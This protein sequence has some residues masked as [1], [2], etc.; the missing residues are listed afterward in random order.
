MQVASVCS[1]SK[2]FNL[3]IECIIKKPRLLIAEVYRKGTKKLTL[4]YLIACIPLSYY[5]HTPGKINLPGKKIFYD[6]IKKKSNYY[7]KGIL[8]GANGH[9]L[10]VID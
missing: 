10:R 5:R 2:I 7:K 3:I 4:A 1:V 6:R 8:N 9:F